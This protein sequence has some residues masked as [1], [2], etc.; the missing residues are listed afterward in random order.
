MELKGSERNKGKEDQ[1]KWK[2]KG[3]KF[4][5]DQKLFEKGN[6]ESKKNEKMRRNE[7]IFERRSTIKHIRWK[8]GE[9]IINKVDWRRRDE[10]RKWKWDDG[11]R[12]R[13]IREIT[14]AFKPIESPRFN[15]SKIVGLKIPK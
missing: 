13:E 12:E 2:E 7:E 6:E 3:K 9:R 8:K 1:W 10:G 11:G 14:K 5:Y 4:Y 15:W